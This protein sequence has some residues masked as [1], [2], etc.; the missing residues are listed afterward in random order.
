MTARRQ[1]SAPFNDLDLTQADRMKKADVNSMPDTMTSNDQDRTQPDLANMT[2]DE[3]RA[4]IVSQAEI[5]PE[6]V[7]N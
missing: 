3:R 5:S 4:V 6:K 1:S 7:T 2:E